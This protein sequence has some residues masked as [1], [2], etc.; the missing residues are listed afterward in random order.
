MK[1]LLMG[2][3]AAGTLLTGTVARAAETTFGYLYTTDTLPKGKVELEQ[4]ITDREGQAHGY[5]H[6]L[7]GR[8][9]VEYGVTNNFQAALYANYAHISAHNNSVDHL[10]EG[11]DIEPDHDPLKRQ[12]S[13][14]SDGAS[15][16]LTWRV[17]SPYTHPI[18]VAFIIEPH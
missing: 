8:T 5:Y 14:H 13:W 6:G 9:E 17:A 11:L 15:L 12:S 4:W 16:E 2:L 10:T 1:T 3:A 7:Y 18:G